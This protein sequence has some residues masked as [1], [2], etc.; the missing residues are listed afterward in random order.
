VANEKKS[1]YNAQIHEKIVCPFVISKST[2]A[3]M[4]CPGKCRLSK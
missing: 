4:G 1:S 2:A 3:V